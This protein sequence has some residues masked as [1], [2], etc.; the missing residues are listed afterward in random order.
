MCYPPTD[1]TGWDIAKEES[2]CNSILYKGKWTWGELRECRNNGNA[3]T[4]AG[5][6]QTSVDNTDPNYLQLFGTF[7]VNMISPFWYEDYAN[8]NMDFYR[9]Y[10]LI[11]QPFVI[12]ISKSVYVIGKTGINVMTLSIIAVYK[13]DQDTDYTL[14]LLTEAAEYMMLQAPNLME[15]L[16]IA[17]TQLNMLTNAETGTGNEACLNN[18]AY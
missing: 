6:Q 2:D 10:Q 11:S 17:G 3:L 9:V 12:Q 8:K 4:D 16:T 1:G 15:P 18:K 14:I 13:E 7:Y 5:V